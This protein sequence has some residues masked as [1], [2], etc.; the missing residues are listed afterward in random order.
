MAQ[1][2]RNT[3]SCLC[4]QFLFFFSLLTVLPVTWHFSFRVRVCSG[5][6]HLPSASPHHSLPWAI[7]AN[8]WKS[9]LHRASPLPRHPIHS[10]FSSWH[11]E[12]HLADAFAGF[13]SRSLFF[14]FLTMHPSKL[15]SV[16]PN[17]F[18]LTSAWNIFLLLF[19]LY[20]PTLF[21]TKVSFQHPWRLCL[22]HQNE[23]GSICI[24]LCHPLF[25]FALLHTL[26][27]MHHLIPTTTLWGEYYY[28]S[29]TNE[30]TEVQ[31]H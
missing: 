22:S 26:H 19:H 8:L 18:A 16:F 3:L 11:S 30:K 20:T 14:R 2:L 27:I 24:F 10:W 15:L 25:P 17:F 31:V 29:Y 7:T 28:P 6:L 12:Q 4:P 23:F 21:K 13:P 5:L 1:V 9:S